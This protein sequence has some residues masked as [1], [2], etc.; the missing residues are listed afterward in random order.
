MRKI[1]FLTIGDISKIATM[2]RALGMANPM[3]WIV[4]KIEKELQWNVIRML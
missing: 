4:K 1:T 3:R 2:K